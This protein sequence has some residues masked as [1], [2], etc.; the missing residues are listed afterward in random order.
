MEYPPNL[1]VGESPL[2]L[3]PEIIKS[4]GELRDQ[5]AELLSEAGVTVVL[6]DVKKLY[7]A[8]RSLEERG[9][10]GRDLFLAIGQ[11]ATLLTL[12]KTYFYVFF[13][14]A[15][16]GKRIAR[17]LTFE[18]E[19][20]PPDDLLV[21]E[22]SFGIDENTIREDASLRET[23]DQILKEDGANKILS[24]T[25]QLYCAIKDMEAEGLRAAAILDKIVADGNLLVAAKHYYGFI[26][27]RI[28]GYRAGQGVFGRG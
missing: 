5:V 4:Q 1:I 28:W 3:S 18:G 21:G 14:T 6:S 20:G 8:I 13:E 25:Q 9:L 2:E 22:L 24:R 17:V 19:I 26:R 23:G 27:R 11:D 7:D 10:R 16:W 15:T 12:F